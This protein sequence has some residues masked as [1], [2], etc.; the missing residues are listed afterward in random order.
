MEYRHTRRL[1]PLGILAG[2][3]GGFWLFACRMTGRTRCEATYKCALWDFS[4]LQPQLT[5]LRKT[6]YIL[7]CKSKEKANENK[8]KDQI[9]TF[10]IPNKKKE[11]AAA[12]SLV[13]SFFGIG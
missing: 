4:D 3:Q 5:N 7:A 10:F 6:V 9:M 8:Q 12:R 2:W 13:F 11:L 1:L